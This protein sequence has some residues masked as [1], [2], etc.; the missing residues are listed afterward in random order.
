MDRGS[1]HKNGTE[2]TSIVILFVVASKSTDPTAAS[3]THIALS[4]IFMF[5]FVFLLEVR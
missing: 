2:A 5:D 1:I 3:E 4:D